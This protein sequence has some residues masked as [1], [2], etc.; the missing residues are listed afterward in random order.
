MSE[1]KLIPEGYYDVKVKSH[2]SGLSKN[3]GTPYAWVKFD[4]G[5]FWQ[6]Y[7]TELTMD[8][9]VEQLVIMGFK[10][11]TPKDLQ[12]DGALN[13]EAPVSVSVIHETDDKGVTRAKVQWVN[14]L[15][16][17]KELT[18]EEIKTLGGIDLRAYVKSHSD[19]AP[20]KSSAQTQSTPDLNDIPF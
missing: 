17:K 15:Y 9:T 12:S 14:S 7:F 4:N 8:K 20:L 6:G 5:L 2:G 18:A 13:C 10:G 1:K 3:K 11:S 19:K 16:E